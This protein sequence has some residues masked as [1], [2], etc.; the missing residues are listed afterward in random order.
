MKNEGRLN[1]LF[2]SLGF[3]AQKSIKSQKTYIAKTISLCYTVSAGL[4]R[5]FM[6][7]LWLTVLR[8]LYCSVKFPIPCPKKGYGMGTLF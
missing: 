5:A 6:I 3:C 4:S 8:L 2:D 1:L 7:S